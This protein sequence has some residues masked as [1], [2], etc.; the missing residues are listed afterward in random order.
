MLC[1][2]GSCRTRTTRNNCCVFPFVYRGKR[3]TR[4]S[5]VRSKG[6]PWCA[7]TPSYDVDKL[8]GY[9][10]GRGGEECTIGYVSGNLP[11]YPS[12][13]QTFCPKRE[14]SVHVSLGMG[15]RAVSQKHTMIPIIIVQATYNV[16]AHESISF[17]KFLRGYFFFSTMPFSHREGRAGE[18]GKRG[19]VVRTVDFQSGGRGFDSSP[20][21]LDGF[22][23]GGPEFK[24]HT[25]CK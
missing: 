5:T 21:P 16:P 20:L 7:L 23:F 24:S 25:L 1:F 6:R 11:T 4:C 17:D 14:V 2:S 19:L 3:Y 9:C 12:P 15:R 8:W 18:G 10:G 22:V 13:N